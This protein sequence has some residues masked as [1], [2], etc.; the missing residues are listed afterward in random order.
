MNLF[1]CDTICRDLLSGQVIDLFLEMK[2][3]PVD[4]AKRN[5]LIVEFEFDPNLTGFF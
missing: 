1:S 2:I 5:N 4:E 3:L